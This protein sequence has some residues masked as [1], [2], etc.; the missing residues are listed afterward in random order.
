M[1]DASVAKEPA[2]RAEPRR[3][4]D[5]KL[6]VEPIAVASNTESCRPTRAT[7]RSDRLDAR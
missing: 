4:N 6:R 5:R 2:D 3:P 7:D 1:L